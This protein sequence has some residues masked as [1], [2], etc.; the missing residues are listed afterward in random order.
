MILEK[1]ALELFGVYDRGVP[2][3]ERIVLRANRAVAL[4]GY[5]LILGIPTLN[6]EDMWPLPDQSLWLGTGQMDVAGWV[7]V[8]TGKGTPAVSQET[9]TKDPL[10]TLYWNKSE[11][12][13][14]N[15][16]V[17]PA[18]VHLDGIEI[19]NR[20]NK[21]IADIQKPNELPDWAEILRSL[22]APKNP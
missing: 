20:P 10:Q 12:A 2:N 5:F 13:L 18:L 7:F 17:V 8:F 6:K 21:S 9:H 14:A 1:P 22:G 19:G 3:L 4:G 11:V 15:E 16:H